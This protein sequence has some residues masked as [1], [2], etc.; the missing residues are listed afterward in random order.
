MLKRIVLALMLSV[1]PA[2]PALAQPAATMGQPAS[3]EMQAKLAAAR[4]LVEASKATA[5]M[6]R[7]M[8]LM[9]QQLIAPLMGANNPQAKAAAEAI[10]PL[11]IKEMQD[12]IASFGGMIAQVYAENYTVDEMKALAAFMRSPIGQKFLDKQPQ[13][14]QA[15]MVAGQKFGRE[16]AEGMR[17]RIEAELAKRGIK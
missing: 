4:D 15:S 8:P 9:W 6:A 13:V 3:P 7:L 10:A 16:L 1:P 11:M 12:K 17:P 2:V 5:M 14:A